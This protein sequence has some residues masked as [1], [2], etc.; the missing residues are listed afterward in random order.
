[1]GRPLHRLPRILPRLKGFPVLDAVLG[2]SSEQ[3]AYRSG[4]LLASVLSALAPSL[5]HEELGRAFERG[6]RDGGTTEG[7]D[8]VLPFPRA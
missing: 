3:M 4:F 5:R 8:N 7:C 1:M 2:R 6:L